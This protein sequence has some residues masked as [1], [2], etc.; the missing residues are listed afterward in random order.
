MTTLPAPLVLACSLLLPAA[1]GA[2]RPADT[3]AARKLLLKL[4]NEFRASQKVGA[5]SAS[6]KLTRAA[7]AVAEA[8]AKKDKAVSD[9]KTIEACLEKEGYR[10]SAWRANVGGG[11]GDDPSALVKRLM[12]RWQ[13]APSSR[14]ALLSKHTDSGVGIARNSSGNWYVVQL[15]ATPR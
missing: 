3:A 10:P 9:A 5:L 8:V 12:A 1:G 4:S 7:Q 11:G 13:D 2:G 14:E 6:E 15:I